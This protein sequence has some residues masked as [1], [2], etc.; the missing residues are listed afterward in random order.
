MKKLFTFISAKET[1]MILRK[2]ARVFRVIYIVLA[3]LTVFIG[4]LASINY[5]HYDAF[6]AIMYLILSIVSAALILLIGLLVEALLIGFSI[7]VRNNYEELLLKDKSL[8]DEELRIGKINP[9]FEKL[10]T[11]NELKDKNLITE[12]EYN[13]KRNEILKNI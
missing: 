13:E 5:Y 8:E 2:V 7:I 9:H 1:Y 3:C 12:A 4:L 6:G 10:Q 11:I